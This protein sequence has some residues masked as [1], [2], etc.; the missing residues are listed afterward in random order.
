MERE[1]RR[2][3]ALL[4]SNGHQNDQWVSLLGGVTMEL[5]ELGDVGNWAQLLEELA[6]DV[7]SIAHRITAHSATHSVGPRE[8]S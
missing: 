2:L 7:K 4:Q 3:Q 6:V 1:L 5:K 8:E